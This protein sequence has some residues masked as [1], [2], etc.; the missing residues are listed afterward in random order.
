MQQGAKKRLN[1]WQRLWIFVLRPLWGFRVE[2]AAA[3]GALVAFG[4]VAWRV[5][6]AVAGVVV[7]GIAGVVAAVPGPRRVAGRVLHRSQLRRR[8]RL[9]VRHARL[10]TSTDRVPKVVGVRE[11]PSGD[12]LTSSDPT[13][14]AKLATVS[15]G[16]LP[17][18]GTTM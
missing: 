13:S 16:V 6:V 3:G 15:I 2:L 1:G 17:S 11:I 8:W 4:C 14:C 12:R 10:A 9:A 7:G 5:G 18:R